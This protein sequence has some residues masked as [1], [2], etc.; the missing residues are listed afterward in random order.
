M[1]ADNLSA[2]SNSYKGVEMTDI[3]I[4]PF[5]SK[6]IPHISTL[7]VKE[8]MS[9]IKVKKSTPPGDIPAKIIKEF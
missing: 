7:K 8:Y 9:K 2:I 3:L 5:S 6:D 1:I 4:P